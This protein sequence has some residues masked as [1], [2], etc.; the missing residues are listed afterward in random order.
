MTVHD[1]RSSSN[2]VIGMRDVAAAAGVSMGTVSN[3][4]NRPEMVSAK[5]RSRVQAAMSE[6]GFVRNESARQLRAGHSNTLAYVML[7]G[8]NP[9]FTDVAK[10][11]EEAA[12][13]QIGRAHV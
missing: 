13:A 5:T 12:E 8:A 1:G 9:F 7:D 3:V 10:G 2:Q 11:I 4:L 6:L